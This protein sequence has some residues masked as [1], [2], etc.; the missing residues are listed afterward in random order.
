M[1]NTLLTIAGLDPT[2]SAGIQRYIEVSSHFNCHCLSVVSMLTEQNSQN[3]YAMLPTSTAFMANQLSRVL[4]D[5]M[6]DVTCISLL[7]SLEHI[8]LL[9][10]VISEKSLRSI[11]LDPV[12]QAGGGFE[13]YQTEFIRSYACKL[14]PLALLCT[15]NQYE[16]KTLGSTLSPKVKT[17]SDA[18]KAMQDTGCQAVMITGG[19][20]NTSF[21][22][23]TLYLEH[24]TVEF[25][26]KKIPG[27]FHG[28]G[29]TLTAAIASL[30]A[31]GAGLIDACEQA[32]AYST[33]TIMDSQPIGKYQQFPQSR[34]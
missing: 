7:G 18:A 20:S 11:V 22:T 6:P 15:P 13:F 19:D 28:T 17:V 23:N 2:G 1:K 21:I 4:D 31:N 24:D 9:A 26:T 10:D 12:I 16:A 32:L 8:K 29:C 14:L 30:I 5:I 25:V 34:V 27:Q 3:V 33:K